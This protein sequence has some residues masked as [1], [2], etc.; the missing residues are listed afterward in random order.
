MVRLQD[1]VAGFREQLVDDI[2]EEVCTI[3]RLAVLFDLKTSTHIVGFTA[4][5]Q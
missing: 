2:A 1:V 5:S 3:F 4:D